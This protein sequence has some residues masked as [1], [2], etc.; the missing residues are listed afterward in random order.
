MSALSNLTQISPHT[1]P[2]AAIVEPHM[3][4]ACAKQGTHIVWSNPQCSFEVGIIIYRR[5]NESCAIQ[6]VQGTVEK[7]KKRCNAWL[8]AFKDT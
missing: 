4:Q 1:K 5:A 2:P 8:T 6:Y 3:Y 7:E